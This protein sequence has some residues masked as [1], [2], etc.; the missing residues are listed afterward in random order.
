MLAGNQRA[1]RFYRRDGW[2][3]DGAGKAETRPGGVILNELRY[4]RTL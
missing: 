1:D 3:P 4:H 2:Q